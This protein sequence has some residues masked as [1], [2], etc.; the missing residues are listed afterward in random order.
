M[1]DYVHHELFPLAEDD[2]DYR[3]L[4]TDHV[5]TARFNGSEILTIEAAALT[6]LSRQ[7]FRDVAHYLRASH[8]RQ[9]ASLTVLSTSSAEV[10][11]IT[12]AR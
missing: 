10:P 11:P 2:T 7:A 9:L 6:G 1:S 4:T 12:T 5:A 3:L 8:L